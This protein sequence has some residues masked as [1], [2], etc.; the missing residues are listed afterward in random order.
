MMAIGATLLSLE[1]ILPGSCNGFASGEEARRGVLG[2]YAAGD[3]LRLSDST[4]LLL[5]SYFGSTA[6]A[7]RTQC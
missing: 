4:Q 3:K 7:R 2:V 1:A 5:L 6:S